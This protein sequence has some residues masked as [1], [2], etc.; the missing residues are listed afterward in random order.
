MPIIKRGSVP[1]EDLRGNSSM[2]LARANLGA[3]ALTVTQITIIPGG[4]VSL[5][6]HPGHEECMVILSGA[7]QATM[8]GRETTVTAGYSIIAPSDV[9][10][11]LKNTSRQPATLIAIFPTTDVQRKYLE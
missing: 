3:S 6:T 11:G 9:V 5:H 8:D 10:H 7:L 2:P 4:Q 1:A